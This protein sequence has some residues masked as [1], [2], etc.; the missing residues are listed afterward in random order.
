MISYTL[1]FSD[2]LQ[3]D[4]DENF[5]RCIREALTEALTLNGHAEVYSYDG[6]T[7]DA[8]DHDGN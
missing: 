1:D 5:R 6:I 3:W 4:C 2:T 7:L 8:W